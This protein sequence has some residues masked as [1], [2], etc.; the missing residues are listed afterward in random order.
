MSV[1]D[2]IKE[3]GNYIFAE[4][5]PGEADIIFVPGNSYPQMAENAAR[6]YA[7]G[8]APYVLPS[9]RYS[10]TVGAFAGV[11]DKRDVY[12]GSYRTEWEFLR[13]VLIKNGVP[14]ERILKEDEATYTYENAIFSR[15]C[16]DRAGLSIKKAILCCKN[17]HARRALLYYQR[18]F[19]E[20]EFIVCPSNVGSITH[21][22][23]NGSQEG[24]A[25]VA[26]EV[27]RILLQFSLM[28]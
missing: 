5:A 22:N 17:T 18:L 3:V 26:G 19:P 23:W 11:M 4:D 21:E 7:M 1:D 25:E 20:T 6:L 24:I 2:F 8:L 13:D 9:G 28:M 10:K 14:G 12:N 15:A 16:T 27:H